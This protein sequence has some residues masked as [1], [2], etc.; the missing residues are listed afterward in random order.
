MISRIVHCAGQ[1][2]QLEVI[3]CFDKSGYTWFLFIYFHFVASAAMYQVAY[4]E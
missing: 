4:S 3:Q 1:T 2:F